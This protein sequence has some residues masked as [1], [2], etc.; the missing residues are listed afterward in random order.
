MQL[1]IENNGLELKLTTD[2]ELEFKQLFMA[3]Q[4]ATGRDDTL[5]VGIGVD[6][7]EKQ[8]VPDI[9]AAKPESERT[10][11]DHPQK[12]KVDM[13]CP[14]CGY[15]QTTITYWGNSYVKCPDCNEKL[16][17]SPA[18]KTYGT[19]DEHG[20]YYRANRAYK[21]RNVQT[22]GYSEMF[23]KSDDP[24]VPDAYSTIEEIKEYLDENNINHD[25]VTL[26]GKL[27]ELI[28]A[29]VRVND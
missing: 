13:Q 26:K 29:G 4:L 15:A 7:P 3:Y 22:N 27:L 14:F 18:N 19:P 17:C 9:K 6:E 20:F 24:G 8:G 11:Y 23:K 12:V 5:E 16:F 21:S 10:S 28:K 2:A 25:G 1:Q